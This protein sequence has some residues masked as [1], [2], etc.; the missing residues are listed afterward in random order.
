MTDVLCGGVEGFVGGPFDSP[1]MEG[2]H[3]NPL[4]AA[5]QKKKKSPAH[6]ELF[7]PIGASFNES[8][9]ICKIRNFQTSTLKKFAESIIKAK[10]GV[11]FRKDDIQD[12]Y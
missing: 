5:V 2:L 4:M 11:I 8:V 10:K 6:H 9:D 3:A 12:A 7:A 1:P